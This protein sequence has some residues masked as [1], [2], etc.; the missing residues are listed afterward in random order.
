MTVQTA[1]NKNQRNILEEIHWR[2]M[3]SGMSGHSNTQLSIQWYQQWIKE[4]VRHANIFK[5]TTA[6]Q[7]KSRMQI[8][9]MYAFK[10]YAKNDATLPYWDAAPLIFPFAEDQ[11]HIWG[12]NL[13]YIPTRLRIVAL[14]SLYRLQN[15][16]KMDK[17]TRLLLSYKRLNQIRMAGIFQPAIKCYLKSNFKSSF[18]EVEIKHWP[19]AAFLPL[20]RWRNAT[21]ST[22][23]SAFRKKTGLR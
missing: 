12:I 13:H 20:A 15:N 11:D 1:A 7:K 5:G 14:R 21:A 22:V 2:G 16:K 10:Y 4:N 23:Y 18:V 17:S 8:G 9:R 3:L 6:N 19:I